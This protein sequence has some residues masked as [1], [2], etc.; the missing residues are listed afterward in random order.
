MRIDAAGLQ[1]LAD[2][3]DAGG[4]NVGETTQQI[5]IGLRRSAGC[6][7]FGAAWAVPC[8]RPKAAAATSSERRVKTLGKGLFVLETIFNYQGLGIMRP[9]RL[10]YSS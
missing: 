5:D 4:E 1:F 10:A 3:V 7:A 2:L 8:S 9:V 6:R